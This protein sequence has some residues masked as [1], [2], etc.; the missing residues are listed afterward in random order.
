MSEEHLEPSFAKIEGGW[1][2]PMSGHV[3]HGGSRQTNPLTV[4]ISRAYDSQ[5]KEIW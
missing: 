2:E 3:G 1:L 5:P 4:I